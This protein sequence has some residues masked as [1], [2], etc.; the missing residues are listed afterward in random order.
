MGTVPALGR[1][2]APVYGKSRS[3]PL[4]PFN[5]QQAPRTVLRYS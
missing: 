5:E 1:E 2:D 4:D 3:N